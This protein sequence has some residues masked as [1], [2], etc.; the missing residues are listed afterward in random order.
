MRRGTQP[1]LPVLPLTRRGTQPQPPPPAEIVA[2][3][4]GFCTL[5]ASETAS[6]RAPRLVDCDHVS[7]AETALKSAPSVAFPPTG[8][9]SRGQVAPFRTTSHYGSAL[10]WSQLP[11]APSWIAENS[12]DVSPSGRLRSV[13]QGARKSVREKSQSASTSPP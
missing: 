6:G 8:S 9:N 10:T 4:I 11:G 1:L 13:P 12:A 7:A 2:L 3:C 5:Q